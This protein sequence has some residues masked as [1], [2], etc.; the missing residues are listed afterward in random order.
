MTPTTLSSSKSFS[1]HVL[2]KSN[3]LTN[4]SLIS[5][6]LAIVNTFVAIGLIY[7]YL[8]RAKRD[9]NPPVKATL[10]VVVFFLLSNLFLVCA[11]YAPPED[12]QSVYESMPYW[13]HCVVAIGVIAVGGV[14]WL[15]WVK[16]MPRIGGYRL[17]R[18]VI[19]DDIDGWERAMFVREPRD[20]MPATPPS[21][22]F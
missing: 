5:Y 22:D 9:W 19:V 14:Y 3:V 20:S 21:T 1:T 15:I 18:K 11:P 4:A 12:G 6:P 17:E 2:K 10:P 8:N 16:L 7:L 13:I